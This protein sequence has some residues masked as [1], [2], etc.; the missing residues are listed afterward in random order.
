MEQPNE[1]GT[2]ERDEFAESHK[3]FLHN[4]RIIKI[5]CV[6]FYILMATSTIMQIIIHFR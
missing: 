1:N 5:C 6:L 4:I 2:E 3:E